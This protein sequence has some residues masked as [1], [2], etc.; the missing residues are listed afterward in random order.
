MSSSGDDP[1]KPL[2][3]PSPSEAM[4]RVGG[5]DERFLHNFV[6]PTY[7]CDDCGEGMNAEPVWAMGISSATKSF[8]VFIVV[9]IVVSVSRAK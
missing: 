7:G 9:V 1:P 2:P 3:L 4:R 5:G 8:S 6:V